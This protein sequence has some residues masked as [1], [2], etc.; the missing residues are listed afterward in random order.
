MSKDRMGVGKRKN[1]N[2]VLKKN[3]KGESQLHVACINGSAPVVYHLVEQ[4]H[5]VNIRDNSGWLPLHEAC[6]HGYLEIV[7]FLL[8]KGAAINDRGGTHCNG[9]IRFKNLSLK[10]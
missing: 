9:K 7:R 10:Y 8:D 2:F 4:G 6:N 5:P 3:A 1:R